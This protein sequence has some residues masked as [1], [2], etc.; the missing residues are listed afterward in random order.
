MSDIF[1]DT[2]NKIGTNQKK[3]QSFL[4]FHFM[5]ELYQL[6]QLTHPQIY[7]DSNKI[8]HTDNLSKELLWVQGG[9]RVTLLNISFQHVALRYCWDTV[10]SKQRK[11]NKCGIFVCLYI[12]KSEAVF[13]T[14]AAIP[15]DRISIALRQEHVGPLSQALHP[16]GP[17]LQGAFFLI[18]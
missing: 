11:I 17:M 5:E 12:L 8:S 16:M 6:E 7:N 3:S 15:L 9:G 18:I 13:F 1:P 10:S 4:S 2:R 14:S